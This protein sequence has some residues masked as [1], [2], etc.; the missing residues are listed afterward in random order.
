MLDGVAFPLLA[1]IGNCE[2]LL[3]SE[4]TRFVFLL[5]W[6][7]AFAKIIMP[8]AQQRR[9]RRGHVATLSQLLYQVQYVL[10]VVQWRVA[11]PCTGGMMIELANGVQYQVQC[12]VRR[13]YRGYY[14]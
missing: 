14:G 2:V 4:K 12:A 8:C 1:K 9:T 3:A 13:T 6:N 11:V 10:R 7:G 5:Q